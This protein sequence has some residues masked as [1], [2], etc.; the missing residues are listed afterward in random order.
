ME[1][2]LARSTVGCKL[3][4]CLTFYLTV[5]VSIKEIGNQVVGSAGGDYYCDLKLLLVV[6]DD[7]L[8]PITALLSLLF[9]LSSFTF[10]L[11]NILFY[12]LFGKK[13]EYN[14][15]AS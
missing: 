7:S 4:D 3:G 5:E 9:S 1:T 15:V 8:S 11:G 12:S 2:R 13:F 14:C 6:Q 10:F